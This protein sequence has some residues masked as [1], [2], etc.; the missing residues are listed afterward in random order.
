MSATQDKTQKVTFVY[1]NLYQLYRKGQ[2]A[3]AQQAQAVPAVHRVAP[4]PILKVDQLQTSGAVREFTPA[5]FIGK[6]VPNP[7][8]VLRAEDNRA[9]EG[10]KKNLSDLN[11]LHSRLRF[12]LK[13]L[14]DLVKE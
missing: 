5:E 8:V 14:E 4:S 3:P 2:D 7:E 10:L 13:E 6:R 12:M 1:S 9:L 11:E